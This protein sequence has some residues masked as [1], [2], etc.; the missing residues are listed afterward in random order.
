MNCK[1]MVADDEYIIRRGIISFLRKYDEIEVVA[2]AEDG[3]MALEMAQE[4]DIDIFFVDINMPFLNGLQFIE[5]LKNLQPQAIIVVI[6][7][8]DD[9]EFARTA[10][11]LGVF[12]Y[13]LKPLMEEPFDNMIQ[14]VLKEVSQQNK[15]DKYLK[16]AKMTLQQNKIHLVD[17]F[18]KNWLEGRLSEQEIEERM[19][20]LDISIPTQYAVTIIHLEQAVDKDLGESWDDDLLTYAVQNISNEIFNDLKNVSSCQVENGDLVVISRDMGAEELRRKQLK[21]MESV[22]ECL[23]LKAV[24]VQDTGEG[25]ENLV[26]VYNRAAEQ[27][28]AVKGG[29]SVIKIVKQYIEDNYNREEL[30]LQDVADYT[31]LSPQHLSRI[32]RKEMGITF[33]DYLTKVRIRKAIDLLFEDDLKMYEIAE[34][35]GYTTQHYFS[36]VF[37]KITGVSPAEYRKCA[38][39]R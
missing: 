26:A 28:E 34:R 22:E 6:T 16:W 29:S 3:E 32:F 24:S 8:Y 27:M 33:I 39:K 1:A 14:G 9:F 20:Y 35:V 17:A 19:Q 12:E 37:K 21:C 31:Y 30:T 7:G 38:H 18:L 23:P 13:I 36:N 4:Q 2:E 5:K 25:Y 10:L 11:R 15:E